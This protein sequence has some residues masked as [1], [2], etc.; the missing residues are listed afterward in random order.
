MAHEFISTLTHRYQKRTDFVVPG[1]RRR[2]LMM[3]IMVTTSEKSNKM[4]MLTALIEVLSFNKTW[5]KHS[6]RQILVQNQN[7]F[8]QNKALPAVL[9]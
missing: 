7:S 5:R 4:V 1:L 8:R 2:I 9:D 3:N 6:D